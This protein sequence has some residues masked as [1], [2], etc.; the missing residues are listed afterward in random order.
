MLVAYR[1][2]R[3]GGLAALSLVLGVGLAVIG[4]HAG[5]VAMLVLPLA[6]AAF[7]LAFARPASSVALVALSLPVGLLPLPG[8]PLGMQVVHAVVAGVAGAVLLRRLADGRAPLEVSRPL[9]WAVLLVVWSVVTTASAVDLDVAVRQTANLVAAVLLALVVVMVLPEATRLRRAVWALLAGATTITL[10]GLA[11]AGEIQA[12]YGGALVKDRL[13]GSFTQPNELGAFAMVVLLLAAGVVLGSLRPRERWL[14][15]GAGIPALG[16][17]T[18]SLSRGAWIGAAAGALTLFVLLP[19]ARRAVALAAAPLLLVG[20]LLGAYAPDNPQIQVV[21]QRLSTVQSPTG[22][23]Y[24]D[25]PRIWAEARREIRLDPLTGQGPG[26]FPIVSERSASEAQMVQ[27]A[28]AHNV[29]LTVA[30]EAGLPGAG[31]VVALTIATAFAVRDG[32]RGLDP[33]DRALLAGAVAACVA[34]AG[35][36]LVDYPMRNPVLLV[37]DWLLLGLVVAWAQVGRRAGSPGGSTR[38]AGPRS[39]ALRRAA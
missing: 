14:A 32:W 24:D 11:G 28:H 5:V 31:L 25:R 12:V 13:Q 27:A 29:L 4:A 36:G 9:T 33:P 2:A 21:G 20:A 3:G 26:N 10:P 34:V 19:S 39:G 7:V 22:N 23:P 37:V 38:A 30:A 16:A 6:G 18:L 15:L 8:R 1:L 35:Q 17:L